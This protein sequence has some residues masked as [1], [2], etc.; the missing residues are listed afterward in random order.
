MIDTLKVFCKQSYKLI[1]LL[2][3]VIEILTN[4]EYYCCTVGL[5]CNIHVVLCIVS[6]SF[7][8]VSNYPY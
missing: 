2:I 8:Y 7:C 3:V 1:G 4:D 6:V 5:S